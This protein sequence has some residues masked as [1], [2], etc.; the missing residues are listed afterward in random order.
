MTGIDPKVGYRSVFRFK[1]AS[2]IPPTHAERC[3]PYRR[4]DHDD[5]GESR[6]LGAP[7]PF[8]NIGPCSGNR[9]LSGSSL[10]SSHLSAA[11][12]VPTSPLSF[13]LRFTFASWVPEWHGP[14]S[15]ERHVKDPNTTNPLIA[16]ILCIA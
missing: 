10:S 3:V 16:L 11:F 1:A 14:R 2:V 8:S 9:H 6:F 12:S 15:L 5:R 13:A 4:H 7:I